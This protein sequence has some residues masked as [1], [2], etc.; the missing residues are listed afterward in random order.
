MSKHTPGPWGFKDSAGEEIG[1]YAVIPERLRDHVEFRFGDDPVLLWHDTWHQFPPKDWHQMQLA[2][3]RLIATAPELL[4]ALKAIL[5]AVEDEPEYHQQGMGCGLEDRAI[6]DRY[7][8]MR[9]GWDK[10]V[11]RCRELL[12]QGPLEQARAAITLATKGV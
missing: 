11:F 8:A 12:D 9:H 1:I 3:A 7:D 6:H 10:A 2:N 4:N 5:E